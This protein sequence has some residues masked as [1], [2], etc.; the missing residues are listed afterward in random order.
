MN[1]INRPSILERLDAGEI[2]VGDGG[3]THALEKRGYVKAGPWTPEC[4]VEHPEAV[5]QLHREFVRAGADVIQ[6]FT[7]SYDDHLG[8]E[9]IKYGVTQVNQAACD[10]AKDVAKEGGA[11]VAGCICQTSSLYSSGAGKEAVM[12][13]FREQIESFLE[14]DVDLLIAEFFSFVEEAQWV[15]E[16]MKSTGKPTAIT[17]C[18]GPSGDQ[19]K[20]SPGDCAVR[21]AEAGADILGVNCRFGP[22]EALQTIRLMKDALDKAKLKVHL[23]CQPVCYHTPDAGPTGWVNLPEAPLALEP[24]TLTRWDVHKYARQ[25]YDLG[26]RYIGG[27]CGFEPYHVRAIAEELAPERGRLPAGSEKHSPWG[28]AMK[29][30]GTAEIQARSTRTYWENLKPASGRPFCPTLSGNINPGPLQ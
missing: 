5:R 15:V 16:V 12:K 8:V 3:N 7:F 28:E 13:K 1:E 29:H 6:A 22:H 10:I 2:I 23:M 25:A 4:T 26:V 9:H 24:R 30:H 19:S 21:L 18:I 17:M 14:N 20:V 27:C 11:F